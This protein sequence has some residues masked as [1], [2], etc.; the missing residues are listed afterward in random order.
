MTLN[1]S[2]FTATS[3]NYS[4]ITSVI[5]ADDA[6]AFTAIYDALRTHAESIKKPPDY[7]EFYTLLDYVQGGINVALEGYSVAAIATLKA[8]GLITTSDNVHIGLTALGYGFY[9]FIQE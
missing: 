9:D 1:L 7:E 5:T 6:I 4:T 2:L 3:G 8:V